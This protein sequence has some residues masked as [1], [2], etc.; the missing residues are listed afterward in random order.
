MAESRFGF[1]SG[2]LQRLKGSITG[3]RSPAYPKPRDVESQEA[4]VKSI[5]SKAC[6]H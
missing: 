1:C 3:P 4:D 5:V 2:E 6:F